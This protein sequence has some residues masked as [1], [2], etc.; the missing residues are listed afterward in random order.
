MEICL[1]FIELGNVAYPRGCRGCRRCADRH[2]QQASRER[3]KVGKR[4][5]RTHNAKISIFTKISNRRREVHRAHCTSLMMMRRGAASLFSRAK[6]D[7]ALHSSFHVFSHR[8]AAPLFPPLSVY[9]F[10]CFPSP[11][12]H[13]PTLSRPFL[14]K[15]IFKQKAET[16]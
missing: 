3:P 2:D 5:T 8:P 10:G 9:Y 4:R 15:C 14:R 1:F 12:S 16:N 11:L 7:G 6:S 13:F